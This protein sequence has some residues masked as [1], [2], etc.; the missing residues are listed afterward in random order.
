MAGI[1]AGSTAKS[2]GKSGHGLAGCDLHPGTVRMDG[3][4]AKPSGVIGGGRRGLL[5]G[6]WCRSLVLYSYGGPRLSPH[7]P[8]NHRCATYRYGEPKGKISH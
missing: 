5:V 7:Q 3:G 8:L 2:A 6:W 4:G 1:V